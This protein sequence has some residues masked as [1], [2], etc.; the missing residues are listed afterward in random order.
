MEV[1]GILKSP[2]A[3]EHTAIPVDE[4]APVDNEVMT[5]WLRRARRKFRNGVT[6]IKITPSGKLVRR[7]LF[8]GAKPE[9]IDT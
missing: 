5:L 6:V 2:R 7:Q 8:I 9:V 4:N 3:A 1:T